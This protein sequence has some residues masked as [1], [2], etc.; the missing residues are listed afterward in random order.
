MNI[1]CP[2]IYDTIPCNLHLVCYQSALE[3]RCQDIV[4][5]YTGQEEACNLPLP[6]PFSRHESTSHNAQ[7][8]QPVPTFLSFSGLKNARLRLIKAQHQYDGRVN[9]KAAQDV[10]DLI[11]LSCFI[12]LIN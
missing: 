1:A 3:H 11:T 12:L 5:S 8:L 10:Y 4:P 2:L 6:E 9:K 7:E